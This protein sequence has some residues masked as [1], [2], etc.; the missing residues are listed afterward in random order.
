M[1]NW[2]KGFGIG[3][4]MIIVAFVTAFVADLTVIVQ[5]GDQVPLYHLFVILLVTWF[6]EVIILIPYGSIPRKVTWD[7]FLARSVFVWLP[8][9]A[10]WYL[11]HNVSASAF[12]VG[13]II[14]STCVGY[15][16]VVTNVERS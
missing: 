9:G 15:N 12:L 7:A 8:V 6:C 16:I 10:G 5:T 2:L 1:K 11:A 13:L 4:L 3:L 14:S